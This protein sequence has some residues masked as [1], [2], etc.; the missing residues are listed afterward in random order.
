MEG[1]LVL[2]KQLYV[3]LC[4]YLCAYV[5]FFGCWVFF[6][7]SC[8]ECTENYFSLRRKMFDYSS[9]NSFDE[10]LVLSTVETLRSSGFLICS[11]VFQYI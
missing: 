8:V 2:Q 1:K 4:M 9:S 7:L 11:S 5:F 10:C 3:G 6:P